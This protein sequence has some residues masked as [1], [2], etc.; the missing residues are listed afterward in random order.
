M[1]VNPLPIQYLPLEN[2]HFDRFLQPIEQ[3]ESF[4]QQIEQF[5]PKLVNQINNKNEIVFQVYNYFKD[6]TSFEFKI[7]RVNDSFGILQLFSDKYD[8]N[9]KI[10]LNLDKVDINEIYFKQQGDILN[11]VIPKREINLLNILIRSAEEKLERQE[12]IEK[13]KQFRIRKVKQERKEKL[14]QYENE[15]R[16]EQLRQEKIRIELERQK[17]Q[18]ERQER[19]EREQRVRE[20]QLRE[21]Q[22]RQQQLREQQFREQQFREQQLKEQRL[23]EQKF[24]E[25]QLKEQQ[26]REQKAKQERERLQKI[27]EQK[28]QEEVELQRQQIENLLKSMFVPFQQFSRVPE[29]VP[30]KVSVKVPE[31]SEKEVHEQEESKEPAFFERV[32]SPYSYTYP[33]RS[34]SNNS[35]NVSTPAPSSPIAQVVNDKDLEDLKNL[36]ELNNQDI[37]SDTDIETDDEL[38]KIHKHPSL[39]EV[40]DEEFVMLRKKF[41]E[42]N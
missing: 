6:F 4:Y 36:T 1:L 40:E 31:K 25:Q 42:S 37:D 21:Q 39:E 16:K 22:I 18:K 19:Q 33:E 20:Q 26:I 13:E 8:F 35:S 34:H 10:K 29:R 32:H 12:R 28:E 11:L 27:K 38:T 17:E 15:L 9:L 3:I 23:R 7:Y 14:R 41:N 24:R 5:K 2:F 30:E